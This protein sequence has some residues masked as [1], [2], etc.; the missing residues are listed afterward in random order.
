MV[1]PVIAQKAGLANST[2]NLFAS[3]MTMAFHDC[4][5]AACNNWRVD[6]LMT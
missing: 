5:K 3:V 2:C 4:K 6:V 1:Y